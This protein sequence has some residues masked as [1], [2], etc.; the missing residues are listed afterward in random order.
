MNS[1]NSS[2][3][4][5]YEAHNTK[6]NHRHIKASWRCSTPVSRADEQSLS[7]KWSPIQSWSPQASAQRSRRLSS[8]RPPDVESEDSEEQSSIA[9]NAQTSDVGYRRRIRGGRVQSHLDA[10]SRKAIASPGVLPY[11]LMRKSFFQYFSSFYQF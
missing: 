1:S 7:P 3:I 11:F 4:L 10:Q 8:L 6:G 9:S 5:Q 2:R